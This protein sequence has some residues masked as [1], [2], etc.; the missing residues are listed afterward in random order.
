P[1]VISKVPKWLL[2]PEGPLYIRMRYLPHLLPWLFRFVKAGTEIESENTV[3]SLLELNAGTVEKYQNLINSSQVKSLIRSSDYLNIYQ[4]E[5][6]Y[7]HASAGWELLQR[8]GA[9]L[10]MLTGGELH[11]LEPM[12]APS[13]IRAVMIENQG[14]ATNPYR[15]VQVLS[16]QFSLGGGV[17]LRRE[18]REARVLADGNVRLNLDLGYVES[19]NLVVAAGAWS[20]Q[21][22]AQLGV[23]IP[24]ETERGYHVMLAHPEV[25]P[26]H[27]IMESEHKFVA[28]P[29]EMGIRFAGTAE[30]AGLTASPNYERADILLRLGKRMFPGLSGT[31]KTEWMGHRPS[32]PDS[33][34]VIGKCPDIPNVLFAFGHGHRGLI[35]APMTGEIIADLMAKRQP[36]IDI[37][38]FRPE[39]F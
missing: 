27:V 9:Q 34:P 35:G 21:I 31:E 20:H 30:L 7:K 29:M 11:E 19:R 28:T 18:V 39:R 24:L 13:Y 12:L 2:D 32:L 22:T 17:F 6:S 15:L 1:G 8:Y 36:K 10:R 3:R 25:Q 14:Y 26:R 33:R 5:S 38:P 4:S 23:R 37:T 16:E